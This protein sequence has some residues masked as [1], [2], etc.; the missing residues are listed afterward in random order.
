MICLIFRN[1]RIVLKAVFE[2][3]YSHSCISHECSK[4][5]LFSSNKQLFGEFFLLPLRMVYI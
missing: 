2:K 3:I 1:S 4:S 5:A